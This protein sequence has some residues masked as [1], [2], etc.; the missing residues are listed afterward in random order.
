MFQLFLSILWKSLLP[1]IQAQNHTNQYLK[2]HPKACSMEHRRRYVCPFS[3]S[4]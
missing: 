2:G 3:V 1:Q 4:K